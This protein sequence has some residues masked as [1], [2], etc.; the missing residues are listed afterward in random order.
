M[1]ILP[2]ISAPL[3]N[4]DLLPCFV[5]YGL[6]HTRNKPRKLYSFIS[7]CVK[8]RYVQFRTLWQ[9]LAIDETIWKHLLN[10]LRSSSYPWPFRTHTHIHK[11]VYHLL[12]LNI[13]SHSRGNTI[14]RKD[15][16]VCNAVLEFGKTLAL[17]WTTFGDIS[18]IFPEL[19]VEKLKRN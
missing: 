13:W 8:G 16:Y 10:L 5:C 2:H 18:K 17:R 19:L 11:L 6:M 3:S 14:W 4:H 7:N 15:F 12:V 1:G 9:F